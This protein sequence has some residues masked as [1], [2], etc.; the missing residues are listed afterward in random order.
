MRNKV[1]FTLPTAALFHHPGRDPGLALTGPLA[2]LWRTREPAVIQGFAASAHDAMDARIDGFLAFTRK[3]KTFRKPVEINAVPVVLTGASFRK[4]FTTVQDKCLISGA[5]GIRLLNRYRWANENAT[6]NPDAALVAHF[7]ASRNASPPAAIPV[8][9]PALFQ[10][11]DFAIESRNTFNFYHFITETLCQLCVL[12]E[13][14]FTGRVF[15]HFP[16]HE[17]KTRAF[18]R[19]FVEALFPELSGRVFFERTPKSYARVLSAFN[20]INALFL[21]PPDSF[22]GLNDLAPS[23][24]VWKGS[25]AE[26]ASQA[27]LSMNAIDRNLLRLR[28]RALRALAGKDFSHLPRRFW[29]ARGKEQARDR[30][31]HGEDD[32][33]AMLKL[34][35]FQRVEFE[36]LLPIEQIALM[37]N[38]EMM[39]SYH[40]AGFT[41]MLFA[42][43]AATVIEIGTLQTAIFRWGDFWPLA[44]AAGCRYVAFFA[45]Y[46]K[47]D[48]LTDPAFASEGIVPVALS[49]RGMAVVL[50]YVVSVLGYLP[51]LARAADLARL[52]D[53]LQ[54]TGLQDRA[55]ALLRRH[56]ALIPGHF[57]LCRILAEC[58]RHE[59]DSAG[60]LQALRQAFAA[61]PTRWYTLVQIAW[62][63]RRAG[64]NETLTWAL[65]RLRA[66]FP[67]RFERLVKERQWF[68]KYA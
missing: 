11:L 57:D 31:M 24:L 35:G 36:K 33:L 55:L 21:F 40:G 42:S 54:R 13:I 51:D 41:N 4:S 60:E 1:D 12:D 38:A 62:S 14:A 39:I 37:A 44:N 29:V 50:P 67:E 15:I 23:D 28:E 46:A 52:A 59:G 53:Q 66:D 45:D 19:A 61:D 3:H 16:N 63:A 10:G 48:P 5:A 32:L 34:F 20:F 68:L 30:A 6:E 64:D 18:T 17:E 7:E 27:L 56:A 8:A 26:R 58:L 25:R 9:D 47:D 49:R 65:R 43:E 2:F 22:A